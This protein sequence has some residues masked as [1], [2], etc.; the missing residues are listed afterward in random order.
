MVVELLS[1][2]LSVLDKYVDRTPNYPQSKHE[3]YYAKRKRFDIEKAKPDFDF[4]EGANNSS[5][6]DHDLLLDLY[7][8][9]LLYG[10]TIVTKL[11]KGEKTK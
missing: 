10:E 4:T 11:P 3:A 7:D 9:C 5:A 8:E 6:R 2:G 1:K